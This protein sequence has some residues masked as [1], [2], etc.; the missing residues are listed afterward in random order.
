MGSCS[1]TPYTK[2]GQA[3][4]LNS[5]NSYGLT[6]QSK[7]ASDSTISYYTIYPNP[8]S[9]I[10]NISLSDNNLTPSKSATILAVLYDI[11]GIEKTRTAVINNNG[12]LDV[13]KLEKGIYI[14]KIDINGSIESHQ[15]VIN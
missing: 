10:L 4:V 13:S 2:N 3:I 11:N 12:I 7:L 9:S 14:L 8:S 6:S 1:Q 5:C 15:V